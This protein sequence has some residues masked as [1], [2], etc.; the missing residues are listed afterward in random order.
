MTSAVKPTNLNK[1]Q[2]RQIWLVDKSE[3]F[4]IKTTQAVSGAILPGEIVGRW[5]DLEAEE[6]VNHHS[7]DVQETE[8]DANRLRT[9]RI[10]GRIAALEERIKS[11]KSYLKKEKPKKAKKK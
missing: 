7:Y 11:L 2:A 1:L 10:E 4:D 9:I 8:V 6:P 3:P 5:W